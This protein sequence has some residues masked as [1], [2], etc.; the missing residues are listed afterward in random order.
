MVSWPSRV[1]YPPI[2]ELRHNIDS[3]A[4]KVI[5]SFCLQG[6]KNISVQSSVSLQHLPYD[7]S[8][9]SNIPKDIGNRLSFATQKLDEIVKAKTSKGK[10]GSLTKALP[11]VG[12][13]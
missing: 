4:Q 12:M 8:L 5:A 11:E 13:T 10:S 3:K 7:V 2:W 9:E 1:I 6:V